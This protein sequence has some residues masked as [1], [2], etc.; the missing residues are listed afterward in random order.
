MSNPRA[1]PIRSA[2]DR[3]WNT[4][5]WSMRH[6]AATVGWAV[7]SAGVRSVDPAVLPGEG[8]AAHQFPR[9]SSRRRHGPKEFAAAFWGVGGEQE[10]EEHQLTILGQPGAAA[11]A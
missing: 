8:P 2:V 1:G 10:P 11:F 3:P 7:E 9:D 6:G 5:F 4:T